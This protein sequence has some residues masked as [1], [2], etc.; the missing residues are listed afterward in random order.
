[1]S[2]LLTVQPRDPVIARDGRPF[3]A[4]AGNRMRSVGWPLPSTVA[5]S[6]RTM[7]GHAVGGK[8]DAALIQQLKQVVC[9]GPLPVSNNRLFL[10]APNDA[11]VAMAGACVTLR[12][13]TISSGGTDLPDDLLPVVPPATTPLMKFGSPPAWWSLEKMGE[14]LLTAGD[15]SPNFLQPSG[16]FRDSPVTDERSHVQIDPK[17]LAAAPHMLFSSEGLVLDDLRE[18][19]RTPHH[20]QLLVRI[21]A[22]SQQSFKNHIAGLNRLQTVGGE[23]R[24]ARIQIAASTEQSRFDCPNNV[25]HE[26]AQVKVGD[27][28]RMALATPAIFD[29][30]WRPGWLNEQNGRVGTPPG[31]E[32]A[33]L[34]LRLIAVCNERWEAVS[35][36]S[37]ESR[38][39]KPVKRVVP[40]GGVYFFRVEH[41]QPRT[42]PQLWLQPT[43]DAPED[44]LEGFGLAVWG[45]WKHR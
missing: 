31:I 39:P 19:N 27:G 30:G 7:L 23:R 29:H 10:P 17:T 34:K 41:V 18:P 22:D 36:W 11:L 13:E 44:C 6:I 9:H 43:S 8:F 14:W 40:A 1:M 35:G 4:H 24:I 33:D 15:A 12:P 3:G 42:L 45:L 2:Q 21:D 16:E 20:T 26:L 25:Q 38:G 37:Y 28:V 32:S 5:G